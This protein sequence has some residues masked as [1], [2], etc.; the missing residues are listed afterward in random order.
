MQTLL[1]IVF[2]SSGIYGAHTTKCLYY[3]NLLNVFTAME[4]AMKTKYHIEDVYSNRNKLTLERLL[5]VA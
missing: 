1:I 4:Q 5:A 2:F 3:K